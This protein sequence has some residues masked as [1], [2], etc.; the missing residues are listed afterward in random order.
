MPRISA[1]N[2]VQES[3][4]SESIEWISGDTGVVTGTVLDSDGEPYS[5]IGSTIKIACEFYSASVSEGVGRGASLHISDFVLNEEMPTKV[6]DGAVVPAPAVGKYTFT[7]PADFYE[8]PGPAVD[9]ASGV[10]CAIC[11]MQITIGSEKHTIRFIIVIR[12]GGTF[13]G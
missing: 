10:P 9:L 4:V 13:G 8:V 7:I 2:R 5:L 3:D 11:Y 12:R 1:I 6:L